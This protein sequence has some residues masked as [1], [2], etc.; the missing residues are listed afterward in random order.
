MKGYKNRAPKSGKTKRVVGGQTFFRLGLK[1][2]RPLHHSEDR[3]PWV[4]YREVDICVVSTG[5]ACHKKMHGPSFPPPSPA[6]KIEMTIR[7]KEHAEK[8]ITSYS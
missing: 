8:E 5:R 1:H 2:H 4:R 3:G 7:R 6:E